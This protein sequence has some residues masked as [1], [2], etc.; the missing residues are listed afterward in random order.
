MRVLKT[1]LLLKLKVAPGPI[2]L[3]E[4]NNSDLVAKVTHVSLIIQPIQ[5]YLPKQINII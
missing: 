1:L 4:E 3:E 2:R 5:E